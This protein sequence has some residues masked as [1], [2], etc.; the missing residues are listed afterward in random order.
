MMKKMLFLAIAMIAF[1]G[2]VFATTTELNETIEEQT[3]SCRW[4]I[5]YTFKDGTKSWG[6]WTYGNCNKTVYP[7]GKVVL[8]PIK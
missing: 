4:R 7:D 5:E 3:V 6:A 1:V 2:N 8:T